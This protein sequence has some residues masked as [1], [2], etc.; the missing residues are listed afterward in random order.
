MSLEAVQRLGGS[1]SQGVA[2]STRRRTCSR[3]AHGS[4]GRN[5]PRAT[6][7][8]GGGVDT[9]ASPSQRSAQLQERLV[10]LSESEEDRP[11]ETQGFRVKRDTPN[12]QLLLALLEGGSILGH[13]SQRMQ[14]ALLATPYAR[15]PAGGGLLPAASPPSAAVYNALKHQ[16]AG[17]LPR[18]P[19]DS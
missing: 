18:Y 3:A 5:N 13:N 16:N 4:G 9:V 11:R 1:A 2:H 17:T 12:R 10:S 6:Q 19:D 15:F 14:G 7:R 8:S